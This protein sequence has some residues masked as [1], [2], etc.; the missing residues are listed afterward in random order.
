MEQMILSLI[1]N[2]L[3]SFFLLVFLVFAGLVS[4]NT[5]IVKV[6]VEG[7]GESLQS[8]I[9]RGLTEAMGRVNGRSIE[10]EILSKTSEEVNIKNQTEALPKSFSHP[11]VV[12][13]RHVVESACV[14][15]RLPGKDQFLDANF[16]VH[17]HPVPGP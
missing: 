10:S 3:K 15:G 12:L 5:Q 9:D 16:E 2:N 1:S 4:A 6:E 13:L 17:R 14:L 7:M 11:S 8:A